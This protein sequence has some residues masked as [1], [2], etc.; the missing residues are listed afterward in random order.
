MVDVVANV[1]FP[2]GEEVILDPVNNINLDE[3]EENSIYLTIEYGTEEYDLTREAIYKGEEVL[4]ENSGEE[5]I[6]FSSL[7]TNAKIF[8]E[9]I[10][11]IRQKHT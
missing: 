5:W 4:I 2:D 1:R 7:V 9:F 3:L 6:L 10:P 11:Y 8:L